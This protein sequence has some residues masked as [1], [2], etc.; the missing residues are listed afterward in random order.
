MTFQAAKEQKEAEE[1]QKQMGLGQEDSSLVAMLQ[2][3]NAYTRAYGIGKRFVCVSLSKNPSLSFSSK[4][5]SPEN[6]ISTASCPTW[7]QNTPKKVGKP[8]EGKSEKHT[9]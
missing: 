2:V 9:G 3:T 6:R 8:K 4:D 1:M 7:K 5:R